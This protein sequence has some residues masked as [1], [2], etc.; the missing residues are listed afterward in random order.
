MR[1]SYLCLM[2][3]LILFLSAFVSPV[4]AEEEELPANSQWENAVDIKNSEATDSLPQID[5]V[6]WYHFTLNSK[7]QAVVRLTCEEDDQAAYYYWKIKL[8]RL[9]DNEEEPLHYNGEAK[10]GGGSKETDFLISDRDPGEYYLCV[11]S[12][13][14][15]T[16]GSPFGYYTDASYTISVITEG[17]TCPARETVS[18]AGEIIAVIGGKVYIKRFD[19]EAYVGYY[20]DKNRETGVILLGETEVAVEY[21]TP[22]ITD[23]MWQ[24]DALEYQ[25]KTYYYVPYLWDAYK[26]ITDDPT[27]YKCQGSDGETAANDLL[28]LHFGASPMEEEAKVEAQRLEKKQHTTTYVV[29]GIAVIVGIFALVGVVNSFKSRKRSSRASSYSGSD[30]YDRSPTR[31]DVADMIDM[32]IAERIAKNMRN[33]NYDPEGP[34]TGPSPEDFPSSNDIW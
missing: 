23:R 33:P 9:S 5:S 19:G 8:Y 32:E 24:I 7:S 4:R 27:L 22:F 6:R 29:I 2:L 26:G 3:A 1:K 14:A 18:K 12:Y 28:K 20:V 15:A 34:S 21:Y 17:Y 30:S 10:I 13:E 16:P 25:D 11:Q 31:Q